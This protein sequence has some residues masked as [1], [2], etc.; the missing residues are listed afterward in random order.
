[1]K[2]LKGTLVISVLT[3]LNMLWNPVKELK[4]RAGGNKAD[5]GKKVE[6]GEGIESRRNVTL[7]IFVLVVESGEG[8]E[9]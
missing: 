8:I 6:S 3:E 2:E 9:R 1:M 7:A 4:D 5:A